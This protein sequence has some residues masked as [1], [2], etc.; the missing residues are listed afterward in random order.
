VWAMALSRR[1]TILPIVSSERASRGATQFRRRIG[2]IGDI[3]AGIGV[4]I[5]L[6]RHGLRGSAPWSSSSPKQ[7]RPNT[8]QLRH[9]YNRGRKALLNRYR[10]DVETVR[11]GQRKMRFLRAAFAGVL[12]LTAPIA[13][14]ARA[15]TPG[16]SGGPV[17]TG[18]APAIVQIWDGN[19]PGRHPMAPNGWG[20]G[21]HPR[22]GRASRWKGEWVAPHWG[23]NPHFGAWGPY[24]GPGVPTYWV[25][26][27]SGGAFDYPFADWRGPTGGWGNP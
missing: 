1:P 17:S 15:A 18:P 24:P 11:S 2:R 26:G 7:E 16:S 23:P 8:G 12:V 22:A 3:G 14:D 5:G 4:R 9:R 6:R 21:W 19:G 20:G 10:L 13:A 25:W 27:P